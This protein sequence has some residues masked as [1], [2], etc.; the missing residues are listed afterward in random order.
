MQILQEKSARNTHESQVK[1]KTPQEE[2]EDRASVQPKPPTQQQQT[3]L[4]P[5]AEKGN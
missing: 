1:T 2:T 4:H 5:T 3:T